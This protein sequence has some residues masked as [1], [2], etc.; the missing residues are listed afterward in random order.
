M[1]KEIESKIDELVKSNNSIWKLLGTVVEILDGQAIKNQCP[2][3]N[4]SDYNYVGAWSASV[5][6][7]NR[8]CTKCLMTI[9][10]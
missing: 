5:P 3:H 1:K 9:R 2:P 8:I 10:V 7:P 4:L 6:P